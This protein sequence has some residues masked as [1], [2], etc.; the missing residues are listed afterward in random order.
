[1]PTSQQS[2][3]E[4]FW[5]VLVILSLTK[6][7]LDD[8][9]VRYA[10]PT[11]SWT[12]LW[13]KSGWECDSPSMLN[14]TRTEMGATTPQSEESQYVETAEPQKGSQQHQPA[15]PRSTVSLPKWLQDY[16]AWHRQVR[17]ELADGASLDNYRFFILR[18]R[19]EDKKCAGAADRLKAIP[20]ALVLCHQTK[21]VLLIHWEKPAPLEEF[22]VPPVDGLD[23]RVPEG[24][25]TN[26]SV[27]TVGF[28][29]ADSKKQFLSHPAP[30]VGVK[31]L[32]G[33]YYDEQRQRSEPTLHQVFGT[34]WQVMFQP[35]PPV[36]ALLDQT[37]TELDLTPGRYVATHVR[38]LYVQNKTGDEVN[39]LRCATELQGP[40]ATLFFTSDSAA[41]TQRAVDFAATHHLDVRARPDHEP[42]HLDR[43]RD[44]LQNSNDWKNHHA[45]AYYNV[46][47][48]LMLLAQ[49]ECVA[50]G[51]GG[52]GLLGSRLSYRP[53]CSINHRR[54][55][56][57][58]KWK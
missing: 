50:Y 51:A 42:V 27:A 4:A 39:A 36:Q 52:Y 6:V 10:S 33:T 45:S 53:S 22:L 24:L 37:M 41:T 30:L 57:K 32:L 8:G 13:T 18:C 25:L 21:R 2:K 5:I 46:F 16:L 28:K 19:H 58:G 3:R 9:I 43:G 29:K 38:S 54:N 14:S 49:A 55:T 44:F 31:T 20:H 17:R 15:P 56:C 12:D 48:D 26:R 47:V 40:N 34:L 1:M 35:S 7:A 11:S 23:W